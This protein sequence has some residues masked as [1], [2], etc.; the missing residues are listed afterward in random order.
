MKQFRKKV[1]L[2]P[3]VGLIGLGI[4]F[5]L[6]QVQIDYTPPVQA[7]SFSTATLTQLSKDFIQISERVTPAV[8]SISMSKKVAPRRKKT[9]FGDEEELFKRFFDFPNSPDSQRKEQGLGS[10]VIVDANKGYVLT[11]NHVVEDADEINVTL[12]DRRQFKA[13]IV[14]TDPPSDLA[15]IQL[16]NFKDIKAA[17]IGDS[18]HLNVGEWVLAIGNPF[19]LSSSVTAGI[20]SAKGR[21]NVG[22][23]DFENFIQTDAA[24]NPGNSGGALVNIKGEVIGIN[25]AIATRSRGYMGISFAIPSNMAQQ[26]MKSLIT[27]GKVTR[28]QLGVYI[29]QLDSALAKSLNVKSTNRGIVVTGVVDGSPADKAGIQKYDIITG[30]NNN[31]VTDVNQFRNAI[32]LTSPHTPVDI[33]ILRDGRLINVRPNLREMVKEANTKTFKR[34][35]IESKKSLGF[36]VEPLN[37]DMIQQLRIDSSTRGVVVT[38]IDRGSAAYEQGL[39]RGDVIID[40]DRHRIQSVREFEQKIKQYKKGDVVLLGVLRGQASLLVAFEVK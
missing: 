25:T 33:Q 36:K 21:A 16:K 17:P 29:R 28:A 12:S 15:V 32:A 19:G 10:G 14:G 5:G 9:P 13:K 22:V 23:A 11:N 37:E 40:V 24:V 38:T 31:K 30:L 20:I 18:S 35:K 26:V 27:K 4:G 34:P 7:Q 6:S 1:L 39:R 8:V 3:I 2:T